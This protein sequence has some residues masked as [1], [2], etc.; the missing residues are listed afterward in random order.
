MKNFYKSLILSLFVGG[1]S[2]LRAYPEFSSSYV[3]DNHYHNVVYDIPQGSYYNLL[4]SIWDGNADRKIFRT[5]RDI[6]VQEGDSAY[7]FEFSRKI[8]EVRV[9]FFKTSMPLKLFIQDETISLPNK[10]QEMFKLNNLR[11]IPNMLGLTLYLISFLTDDDLSEIEN[12]NIS[13]RASIKHIL[14]VQYDQMLDSFFTLE[15]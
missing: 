12:A 5:L 9:N 2:F 3:S 1:T 15:V 13:L 4:K 11:E 14:G 8:N 7:W 10:I 6:L